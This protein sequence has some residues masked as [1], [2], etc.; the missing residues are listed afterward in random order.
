MDYRAVYALLH[1][2]AKYVLHL[3][4]QDAVRAITWIVVHALA[5][6]HLVPDVIMLI[7]II[8]WLGT[9]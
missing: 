9:T 4:A 2:D 8:V 3:H 1:R 5:A 7:A 6:L